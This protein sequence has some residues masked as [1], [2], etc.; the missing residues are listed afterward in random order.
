[1]TEFTT[2]KER[3]EILPKRS[4][5]SSEIER[6]VFVRDWEKKKDRRMGLEPFEFFH[7]T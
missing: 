3:V 2:H 5:N 1:V 6:K 7:K 4:E